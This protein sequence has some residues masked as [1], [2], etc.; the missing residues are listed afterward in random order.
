[1]IYS[2]LK[3]QSIFSIYVDFVFPVSSTQHWETHQFS[4]KKQRNYYPSLTLKFTQFFLWNPCCS[5]FLGCGFACLRFVFVY[6]VVLVSGLSILNRPSVLSNVYVHNRNK[7]FQ[8]MMYYNT[9]RKPL[10]QIQIGS[11]MTAKL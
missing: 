1:M 7:C 11:M 10:R 6:T 9:V 4:Y 3:F 5:T 8:N 2:F